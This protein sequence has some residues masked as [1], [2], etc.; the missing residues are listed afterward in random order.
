MKISTSLAICTAIA[1]LCLVAMLAVTFAW[2][3]VPTRIVDRES[4]P[5]KPSIT[6]SRFG[7]TA[8]HTLSPLSKSIPSTLF[9][10]R[11]YT[12]I[13]WFSCFGYLFLFTALGGFERLRLLRRRPAAGGGP[14]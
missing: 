7:S 5:V 1:G 11:F 14:P 2:M 13:I 12:P 6:P 10:I 9:V 4:S 8:T 3:Y